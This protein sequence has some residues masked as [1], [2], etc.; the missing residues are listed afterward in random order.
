MTMIDAGKLDR[1]LRIE[2]PVAD[3][4]FGG[5]GSGTWETLGY[6]WAE[7]RDV[8]PSRGETAGQIGT[9]MTRPARVR[10]RYRTDLA[11]DMR[12]VTG[13]ARILYIISGPAMLGRREGVE[14]MV[15]EYLPGGNPA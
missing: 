1:R 4:S 6:A 8:L 7:V 9:T 15:A 13:D 5:A 12:F 2:R 14:L 11:P 3:A 10:M